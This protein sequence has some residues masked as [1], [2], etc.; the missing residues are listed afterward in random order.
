[1][2]SFPYTCPFCGRD[3]TIGDDDRWLFTEEIDRNTALG[4][5]V[6]LGRFVICPNPKCKRFSLTVT[7]SKAEV[8]FVP[9][10]QVKLIGEPKTWRLVPPSDAK[11]FPDYISKQLR[12]NYEEA[13]LVRDLSPKASATL[14]RRCLQGMIRDFWG[15]SRD[16]LKEE[17]DAIK[18]K[19][20]SQTWQAIDAVR[21]IGNIGAHMEKDVNLVVD[22]EPD[23]ARLLI[24]LIE[25]LFKDWHVTKHE[26]EENLK[27]IAATAAAKKQTKAPPG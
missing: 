18:E 14:A 23:E 8:S 5:Q 19:V 11:V 12:D 16:T 27:A 25:T 22:V 6:L 24:W 20:D 15:I 7:L 4:R 1:M 3:A 17:I 21:S 13:C 2:E 10:R 9:S 26:R